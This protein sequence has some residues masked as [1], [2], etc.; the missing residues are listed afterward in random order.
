MSEEIIVIIALV[1][2]GMFNFAVNLIYFR[3]KGFKSLSQFYSLP[4][5]IALFIIAGPMLVLTDRAT[6]PNRRVPS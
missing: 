6:K 2:I 5:S 1:L 4:A 3:K